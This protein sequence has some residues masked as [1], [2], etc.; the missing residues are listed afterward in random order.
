MARGRDRVLPDETHKVAELC[1]S[2]CMNTACRFSSSECLHLGHL[3]SL[4]LPIILLEDL[5]LLH[6]GSLQTLNHQ[7]AASVVLG[8][9][10]N[11]A[12][13]TGVPKEV[14]VVVLN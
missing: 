4:F 14:N 13:H 12:G 8:V 2:Y 6:R 3:L 7:P 10:A 5:V 9:S 1:S 11:L